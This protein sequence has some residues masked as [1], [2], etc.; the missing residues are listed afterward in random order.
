MK[1]EVPEYLLLNVIRHYKVLA[2][3]YSVVPYNGNNRAVNSARIADKEIRKLRILIEKQ[4]T[5]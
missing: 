1:I 2:D 5:C 3:A 4:K